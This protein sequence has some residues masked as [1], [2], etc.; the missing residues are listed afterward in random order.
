MMDCFQNN[1][2]SNMV[3]AAV[4]KLVP[5]DILHF[6]VLYQHNVQQGIHSE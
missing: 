4:Y 5:Y 6:P 1:N 3:Y 2:N